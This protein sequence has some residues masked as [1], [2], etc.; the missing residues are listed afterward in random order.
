L[1]HHAG[2]QK[3]ADG[4]N[5]GY[6]RAS[7]KHLSETGTKPL[8][9]FGIGEG[10]FWCGHGGVGGT[11]GAVGFSWRRGC[12]GEAALGFNQTAHLSQD[13]LPFGIGPIAAPRRKVR[14]L[15]H[16]VGD[17]R[18]RRLDQHRHEG[19]TAMAMRGFGDDPL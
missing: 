7:Q 17:G 5:G 2:R 12:G 10:L 3:H 4:E 16:V 18:R 15:H 19:L 11:G 1:I 9:A 8:R 14:R 13:A 6:H